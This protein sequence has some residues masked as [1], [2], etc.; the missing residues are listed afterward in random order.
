MRWVY[1]LISSFLLCAVPHA[2]S[3]QTFYGFSVGLGY[4][5]NP[6]ILA[7]AS[8]GRTNARGSGWRLD[9]FA[10]G[11]FQG[12]Y[13]RP[14][15]CPPRGYCILNPPP[16]ITAPYSA[17][18]AGLAV[19][20]TIP[21]LALTNATT[22]GVV[23]GE[24]DRLLGVQDAPRDMLV[25]ASLGLGVAFAAHGGSGT[26][27]EGRLHGISDSSAFPNWLLLVSV[28]AQWSFDKS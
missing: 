11:T 13:T 14:F 7:E 18:I 22:Y 1:C 10:T 5:T 15:T 23:G 25:G 2:A 4:A 28:G 6:G 19:S 21:L 3:T 17:G 9:A 26:F 16:T 8:F 27:V 24:V 12:E 20:R